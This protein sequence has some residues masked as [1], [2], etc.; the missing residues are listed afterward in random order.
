MDDQS[1][2]VMVLISVAM[3]AM[4]IPVVTTLHRPARRLVGYKRRNLELSKPDGEF[5][6]LACIHGPRNVP[7]IISLIDLANPTK[8]SPIFVYALHLI[9]L[10]GRA[11]SML[12]VHNSTASNSA[13]HQ[14]NRSMS[15]SPNIFSAFD[16]YEQHAGGVSIHPLTTISPY[17]T[18]HEDICLIAEDKH[19]TIIVLPFHKQQTVDGG[20]QPMNPAIRQLNEK[21]LS[22]APC[23]VAV[24]VDRGISASA[25]RLSTGQNTALLFFGGPDDRE[26]LAFASRMVEN[27]S[28]SLTIVRFLRPEDQQRSPNASAKSSP[29][30]ITIVTGENYNDRSLDEKCLKELRAR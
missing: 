25:S 14:R 20:L 23:S 24:L 11:S 15:S 18:M 17:S 16:N 7:S 30:M 8:R 2:A 29:S 3:T 12:V 9:E 1:F 26:A 5:R 19:A 6:L 13:H 28:V 21:I 10:T 22:S 27:P 4:V